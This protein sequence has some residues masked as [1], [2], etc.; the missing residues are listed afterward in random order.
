MDQ[1]LGPLQRLSCLGQQPQRLPLEEEPWDP[2]AQM[3]H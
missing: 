3:G 1:V 2:Q